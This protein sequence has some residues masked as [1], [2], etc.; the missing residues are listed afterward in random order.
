M[1]VNSKNIVPV[2]RLQAEADYHHYLTAV[3]ILLDHKCLF[4]TYSE[5]D[6]DNLADL[7]SDDCLDLIEEARGFA[8]FMVRCGTFFCPITCS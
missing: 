3:N 7:I 4:A 6:D 1:V 5:Y 8:Y 2:I